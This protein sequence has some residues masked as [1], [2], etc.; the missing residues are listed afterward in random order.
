MCNHSLIAINAE[1]IKKIFITPLLLLCVQ[2]FLFAAFL[3]ADAEEPPKKKVPV[4][5]NADKLDYDR[6]NDRYLAEGHVKIR[7]GHN[8]S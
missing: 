8:A 1:M 6:A 5:V 7:A 4:T 3:T 2:L